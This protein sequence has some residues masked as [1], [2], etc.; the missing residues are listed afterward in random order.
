MRFSRNAC[1]A[2]F[3]L[4]LVFFRAVVPNKVSDE[5]Q[6]KE[7]KNRPRNTERVSHKRYGFSLGIIPY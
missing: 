5:P 3:F 2:P 6:K 4:F 7:T 1:G